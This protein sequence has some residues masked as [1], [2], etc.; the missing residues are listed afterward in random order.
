MRDID[1]KIIYALNTSIPTESFKGQSSA[2]EKCKELHAKLGTVHA[3]RCKLIKNCIE[4]TADRVKTLNAQKDNDISVHKNFK[5]EQRKVGPVDL[6]C[7][8]FSTALTFSHFISIV[9]IH[10]I[11]ATAAIRTEC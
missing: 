10:D 2:S 5:S 1:D 8:R 6:I 11:A 4:V 7:I 9:M 3:D